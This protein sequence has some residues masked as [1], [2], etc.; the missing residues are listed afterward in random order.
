VALIAPSIEHGSPPVDRPARPIP[1]EQIEAL[2]GRYLGW[3]RRLQEDIYEKSLEQSQFGES[4]VVFAP[5]RADIVRTTDEVV[6]GYLSMSFAAPDHFGD[7]LDAF[8]VDLQA[9]LSEA[10]PTAGS[11][12]GPGDT[13]I[14]WATK[15]R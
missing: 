14:V 10:S 1:H 11:T 7:R 8:V 15:R 13:I 5:G 9:L 6:S 3:S 12:I 2:I 4:H